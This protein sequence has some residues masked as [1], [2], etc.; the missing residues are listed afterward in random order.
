MN[1]QNVYLFLAISY[2]LLIAQQS[3]A[4]IKDSTEQATEVQSIEIK[5][6][7]YDTVLVVNKRLADNYLAL[8]RLGS[9]K[10]RKFYPGDDLTFKL[11]NQKGWIEAPLAYVGD[12]YFVI[13][14]GEKYQFE[15]INKIRLYRTGWFIN[16]GS[17]YFPIFGL[18][19]LA[20]DLFNPNGSKLSEVTTETWSIMGGF[21]FSGFVLHLLKKH[22][23][24]LNKRVFLKSLQKF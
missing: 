17:F 15:E 6:E 16:Q 24:N 11:K 20:G 2:T 19:Y 12:N 4:Q 8:E 9:L 14:G 7:Q 21:I 3:K 22:T 5:N 23:I 10:R 1:T 13:F 18:F